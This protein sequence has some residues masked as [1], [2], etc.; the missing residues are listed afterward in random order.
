MPQGA[1][2]D[3]EYHRS[4]AHPESLPHPVPGGVHPAEAADVPQLG[5]NFAFAPSSVPQPLQN[6]F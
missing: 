2:S 6:L 4:W 5:Q 3:D 1:K